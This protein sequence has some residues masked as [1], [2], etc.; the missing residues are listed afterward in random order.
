MGGE[1]ETER[2]RWA[3]NKRRK[4]QIWWKYGGNRFVGSGLG[5]WTNGGAEPAGTETQKGFGHSGDQSNE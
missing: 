2:E 5:G 3:L 4:L 1:K